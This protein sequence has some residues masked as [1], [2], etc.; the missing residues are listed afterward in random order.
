MLWRHT[1]NQQ[2]T[3]T[4][5]Y[6]LV[7][8]HLGL[9]RAPFAVCSIVTWFVWALSAGPADICTETLLRGGTAICSAAVA[10][11]QR[12]LLTTVL[13][14][15]Y[16]C[17]DSEPSSGRLNILIIFCVYSKNKNKRTNRRRQCF[18]I[19]SRTK[20]FGLGKES[21]SYRNSVIV[22]TGKVKAWGFRLGP[23]I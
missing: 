1:R 4:L 19:L 14:P 3:K 10:T 7:S 17:F 9:N 21:I 11:S 2:S 23:T 22:H 16:S 6:Y 12:L 15:Q 5:K 20:Y 18:T 8:W 13:A